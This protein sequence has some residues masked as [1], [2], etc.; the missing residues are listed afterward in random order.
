MRLKKVYTVHG[1]LSIKYKSAATF[2][3]CGWFAEIPRGKKWRSMYTAVDCNTFK[4]AIAQYNRLMVGTRQ[5][6]VRE[7]RRPAKVLKHD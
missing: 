5:I 7:R 1:Q 2:N 3:R 6:D 4:H